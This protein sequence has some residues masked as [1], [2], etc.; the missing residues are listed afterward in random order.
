M[1]FSTADLSDEHGDDARI[2]VAPWRSFGRH[3]AFGGL[4][5]TVECFEDNSRVRE[6]LEEPGEG[7]VLIVDGGGSD[8]YALLGDSLATLAFENGWAGVVVYGSIRDSA[9]IDTLPFGVKA[10]GTVPRRSKKLDTGTAGEPITIA[11][12]TI[13]NGDMVVA[14]PDGVIVL[15]RPG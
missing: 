5:R 1:S 2:V 15:P 14:D 4:A 13:A 10:L 7:H 8:R 3:A 11:D 9:V 12:V 6:A